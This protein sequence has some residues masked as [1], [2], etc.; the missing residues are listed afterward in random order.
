MVGQRIEQFVFEYWDGKA[1]QPA[2]AGTTV[3]YKRL[4]RFDPVKAGRVR[5]RITSSRLNPTLSELGLYRMAR[6]R[7][8]SGKR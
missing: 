8:L 5:L 7:V 2:A 6:Y 1:W 4:L 3:G